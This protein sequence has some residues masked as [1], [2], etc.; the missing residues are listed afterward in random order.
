MEA[1]VANASDASNASNASGA[2]LWP[3]DGVFSAEKTIARYELAV[4]LVIGIGAA[5]ALAF[6]A[7]VC[8]VSYVIVTGCAHATADVC[9]DA[10]YSSAC[11]WCWQTCRARL[12]GAEPERECEIDL[13]DLDDGEES[14]GGESAR[15]GAESRSQT[16]VPDPGGGRAGA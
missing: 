1:A 11:E 4:D 10:C 6:A 7:L 15:S 2:A 8:Y 16:F 9:F 14:D 3:S 12:C 13:G 5:A